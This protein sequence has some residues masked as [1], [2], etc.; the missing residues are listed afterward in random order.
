MFGEELVKLARYY[1]EAYIGVESNNHGLTTLKAIQR[2]DY[3][4]IFFMKSFDKISDKI[5]QKIGWQTNARTK[6]LMIDKLAEFI[7]EKWIGIKWKLFVDEC[8]TY[9]IEDNGSTNA[10]DG[11]HDDTVMAMAI[12]LQLLLEGKGENFIPELPQTKKNKT[13][14]AGFMRHRDEDEDIDM[15]HAIEISR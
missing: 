2:L 4:N 6:P 7:R 13:E 8:L 11:C 9:V 12:L 5:T 3:Y 10:Q 1:N 14:S 15:E